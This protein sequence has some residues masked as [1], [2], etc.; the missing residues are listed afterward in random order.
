MHLHSLKVDFGQSQPY[1]IEEA[2]TFEA[3]KGVENIVKDQWNIKTL[4]AIRKEFKF[5]GALKYESGWITE[6]LACQPE[7][8]FRQILK[9]W[10][11]VKFEAG[12]W[13][14]EVDARAA[15]LVK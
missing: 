4:N 9:D 5:I 8:P 10:H 15:H 12:S 11:G 6:V 13:I 1:L 7:S 3:E 2:E 14:C